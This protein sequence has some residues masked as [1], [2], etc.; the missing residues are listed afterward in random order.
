MSKE[1]KPQSIYLHDVYLEI[2]ADQIKTTTAQEWVCKKLGL[3]YDKTKV[4]FIGCT[5]RADK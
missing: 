1:E 2:P 3:D 5:I 4:N